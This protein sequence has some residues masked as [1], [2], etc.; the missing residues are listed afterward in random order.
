MASITIFNDPERSPPRILLQPGLMSHEGDPMGRGGAKN[1]EIYQG[2][3]N[4]EELGSE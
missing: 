4:A 1:I 2:G 3:R